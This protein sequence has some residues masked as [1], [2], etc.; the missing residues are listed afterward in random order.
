ME[1]FDVEHFPIHG[2]S[3]IYYACRNGA[4]PV[5]D[6]VAR[7]LREEKEK[8]LSKR[9]TYVAFARRTEEIKADLLGMLRNIRSAGKRIAGYGAPAKGNTLLNYCGIGEDLVEYTVDKSPHKQGLYTPGMH[10]RVYP[11][12]KLL[13]DMPD[14]VLLLAWN[15]AD[16]ILKQQEEYRVRGGKFILPIPEV[17]VLE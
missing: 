5:E 9:E 15:F 6:S 1:L 7:R 13:T 17:R 2:G 10:L 11:P 4:R 3:L 14:Y 8:G 16:E 12:E